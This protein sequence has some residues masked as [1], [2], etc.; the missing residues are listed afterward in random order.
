MILT[1]NIPRITSQISVLSLRQSSR[2]MPCQP[3]ILDVKGPASLNKVG[4]CISISLCSSQ[5]MF[6][7]LHTCGAVSKLVS[8]RQ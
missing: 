6:E 3:L 1:I 2:T 8:V 7:E 5:Y 4:I